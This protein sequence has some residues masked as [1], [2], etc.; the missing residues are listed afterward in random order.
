MKPLVRLMRVACWR[1]G[2]GLLATSDEASDASDAQDANCSQLDI[3]VRARCARACEC[4]LV[5]LRVRRHGRQRPF[6]TPSP[7]PVNAV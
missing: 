7:A 4:G 2:T 3:C 5:L 6:D 1:Y